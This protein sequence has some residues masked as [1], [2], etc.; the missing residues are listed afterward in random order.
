MYT[1][2]KDIKKQLGMT[3]AIKIIISY[4]YLVTQKSFLTSLVVK[5]EQTRQFV[6]NITL[7]VYIWKY[8]A[9]KNK[10]ESNCT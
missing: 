9:N 3:N 6:N 10:M 7:T 5:F 8:S 2:S 4:E 1:S